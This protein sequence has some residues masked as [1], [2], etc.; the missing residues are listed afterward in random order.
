M[1]TSVRSPHY[2]TVRRDP[3]DTVLQTPCRRGVMSDGSWREPF[4]PN[5]SNHRNDDYCEGTAWQWTW[6]VR[7]HRSL[8][9][10]IHIKRVLPLGHSVGKQRGGMIADHSARVVPGD[11]F[12]KSTYLQLP[13]KTTLP[14]SIRHF[15]TLLS[16]PIYSLMPTAVIWAWTAKQ[17]R[18]M[19]TSRFTP[20]F[21]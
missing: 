9:G 17:S 14:S 11:I 21:L 13:I 2:L 7:T 10:F 12:P 6:F 15:I 3:H 18:A 5:A 20:Y 16:L 4:S 19:S 8:E 1:P